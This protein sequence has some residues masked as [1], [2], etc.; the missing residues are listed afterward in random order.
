MGKG[1]RRARGDFLS[2]RRCHVP[3]LMPGFTKGQR[4]SVRVDALAVH[5]FDE[6]GRSLARSGFGA[7]QNG[8]RPGRRFLLRV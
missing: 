7:V 2:S 6:K 5:L 4:V 3:S 8:S 1:L